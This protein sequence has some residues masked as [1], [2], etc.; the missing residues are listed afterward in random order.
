[1]VARFVRNEKA[2]GSNPAESIFLASRNSGVKP[3]SGSGCDGGLMHANSKAFGCGNS[4]AFAYKEL[5]E[6]LNRTLPYLPCRINEPEMPIEMHAIQ[7]HGD[8]GRMGALK[9]LDIPSVAVYRFM[10]ALDRAKSLTGAYRLLKE[11]GWITSDA[12][13]YGGSGK[14]SILA[15]A[16]GSGYATQEGKLAKKGIESA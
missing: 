16:A 2:A 1:M 5:K 11:K 6:E 12:T 13:I 4:P 15:R 8:A 9:G 14:P 3:D 7:Q 10:V